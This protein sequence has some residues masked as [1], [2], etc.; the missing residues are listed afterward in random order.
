MEVIKK[1]NFKKSFRVEIISKQATM[2]K[3]NLFLVKDKAGASC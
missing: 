1:F 2:N 3:P